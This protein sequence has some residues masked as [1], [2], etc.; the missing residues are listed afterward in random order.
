MHMI[1]HV[2]KGCG[3]HLSQK[4]DR[5]EFQVDGIK[6]YH[7]HRAAYH[8]IIFWCCMA[9]WDLMTAFGFAL[10]FSGVNRLQ[11]QLRREELPVRL[12][13]FKPEPITRQCGL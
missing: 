11:D 1:A 8:A 13:S 6:Y 4:Q 12:C 3:L 5:Q 10:A 9:P 7:S 2:L